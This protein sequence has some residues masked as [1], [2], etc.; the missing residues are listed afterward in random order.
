M[1]WHNKAQQPVTIWLLH[2]YALVYTLNIY[3]NIVCVIYIYMYDVNADT[4]MLWL[5]NRKV[6]IGTVAE[7][8]LQPRHA[9]FSFFFVFVSKII[10][11]DW[12]HDHKCLFISPF[13][14]KLV[15]SLK[16][17]TLYGQRPCSIRWWWWYL[18]C[19]HVLFR[20]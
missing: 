6:L 20:T 9:I 8:H 18:Y 16:P 2:D 12:Y 5:Y 13:G 1:V 3:S 15:E 17:F 19:M 11:I 14:T 4:V 7:H 10:S